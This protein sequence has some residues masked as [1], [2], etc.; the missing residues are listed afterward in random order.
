M[1]LIFIL[2]TNPFYALLKTWKKNPMIQK[3]LLS[4]L[5]EHNSIG[6]NGVSHF[7]RQ[8]SASVLAIGCMQN[9]KWK[10]PNM[11]ASSSESCFISITEDVS[12]LD[13]GCVIKLQN[14]C[15][16]WQLAHLLFGKSGKAF[17]NIPISNSSVRGWSGS[18]FLALMALPH[19]MFCV[20]YFILHVKVLGKKKEE[21]EKILKKIRRI[22]YENKNF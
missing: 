17:L 10:K 2:F 8:S 9:D 16:K 3:T 21:E 1:P 12:V 6:I 15:R 5:E 18:V 7:Y 22:Q 4:D 20:P 11:V 13:A 14:L 19:S